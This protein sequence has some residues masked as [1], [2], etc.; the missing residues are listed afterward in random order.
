MSE[1][2]A[3]AIDEKKAEDSGSTTDKADWKGFTTVFTSS[4]ITGIFFGVV[5]IGS[6]GLFLAKVA[7][8]NILPTDCKMQPFPSDKETEKLVKARDVA[9]DIIYMNPVKILPLYGLKFWENLKSENF[10]IQE[11]NFVNGEA[12][13]NFM[14][15]FKNSWL[16]DLKNKAYPPKGEGEIGDVLEKSTNTNSSSASGASNAS[17]NY[18]AN[19]NKLPQNS[20]FWDY[21][22]KTLKSMT[23]KSFFIINKIFFYMNYMPEWATMFVFALFFS[24]IIMLIYGAI[25]VYGI[26]AHL[27][28][29]G[30]MIKNL[31][32]PDKFNENIPDY[33]NED[34]NKK[35]YEKWSTIS[36]PAHVIIYFIGA[37]YSAL[38]ISPILVTTYVFLKALGA[39]YVV[40]DKNFKG[41]P[42]DAPK[43]NVF[44]FI[45]SSLYY[46]KTFIIILVMINLMSV[47]NVYLGT[48][49][50]PGVIIALIILIFGLKVLEIN[51]PEELFSV[52]NPNF[53]PIKQP[54][55]DLETK[56]PEVDVC[57]E[58]NIFT[59]A[60]KIIKDS[61]TGFVGAN[62]LNNTKVGQ[63]GGKSIKKNVSNVPKPISTPKPKSKIYNLKLV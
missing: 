49:Y 14:N 17:G 39:N 33:Y 42:K 6:M 5:V 62:V 51:P 35:W 40:R 8:A 10:F 13:L 34:N 24:I 27:S 12:E 38:L 19:I 61:V 32:D 53:P 26:W 56:L 7:N 41:D 3:S 50:L 46:K 22:F 25:M 28:N 44:S 45:K 16:C 21:E 29:F 63:N 15:D 37:L 2:E 20:P 31:Y 36:Y 54:E 58:K 59:T 4:L 43:L 11:A 57:E 60:E 47:T 18:K 1:T 48:S 52:L 30:E 55:V 9:M 23:C